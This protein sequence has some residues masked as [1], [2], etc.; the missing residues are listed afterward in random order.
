MEKIK[1]APFYRSTLT[2]TQMMG[3]VLISL[4]PVCIMAIVKFGIRAF[5]MMAVGVSS[6]VLF[7]HL[8]CMYKKK[9]TTIGD[10]SAVV[11]GLLLSL[12]YTVKIPMWMIVF[13]SFVAIII[14]KELPGG[15]GQNKLNP[16]AFARVLCKILFTPLVA[17]WVLPGPDM[18]STATPLEYLSNGATAIS[19]Y[20]PSIN[21]M[22]MGNIGGNI[23]DVV[24][25]PIII[26]FIFLSWRKTIN[27][28]M[29][30][31]MLVGLFL[32]TLLFGKSDPM[33]ALYHVL[34]GTAMFGAVFM[35]TEYTTCPL[36][37]RGKVYYSLFIGIIVGIL[38]Y[39]TGLPGGVGVAI[40]L[41]NLLAPVFDR[42][43]TNNVYNY[44]QPVNPFDE[45]NY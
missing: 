31:T 5:Y 24:K 22:F 12:C 25:W 35:V 6:A 7:E 26:S 32:T 40:L 44:E 33:F 36:S 16:A 23:G 21:D 15:L 38:R 9:P 18:I 1:N 17:Q 19:P 10:L 34:S 28:I 2:P 42:I 14:I 4:I 11:T 8:W 13:G 41:G 27:P 20:L 45:R 39:L 29:P 30:I 43:A 37:V 3:E